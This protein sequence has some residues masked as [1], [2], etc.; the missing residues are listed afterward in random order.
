MDSIFMYRKRW[1]RECKSPD[2]GYR[3]P[4]HRWSKRKA[5]R[6]FGKGCFLPMDGRH[7]IRPLN[8]ER[9]PPFAMRW[10]RERTPPFIWNFSQVPLPGVWV[11]SSGTCH[12]IVSTF[13]LCR[14]R[15]F[16]WNWYCVFLCADVMIARRFWPILLYMVFS[17]VFVSIIFWNFQIQL[18]KKHTSN[19]NKMIPMQKTKI[20]T[21]LSHFSGYRIVTQSSSPLT[22]WL[23]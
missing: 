20:L 17:S 21:R 4:Y 14:S 5:F 16:C 23:Q 12:T 11:R 19:L 8:W 18:R 15:P 9:M 10:E 13:A 1:K 7:R 2:W 6:P 22:Y 3:V